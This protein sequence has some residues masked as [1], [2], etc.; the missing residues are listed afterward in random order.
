MKIMRTA[1]T[2]LVMLL[3]SV[4]LLHAQDLSK[5]RNFSLGMTLAD[6]SKQ[7]GAKPSDVKVIHQQ[8]ALIEELTWWP[9]L[10]GYPPRPEAIREVLFSFCDGKLYRIFV[11]YDDAATAGMTA[12][13]MARAISATYGTSTTPDARISF[14]T[15]GYATTEKVISRWEDSQYSVNLFRASFSST[16][17]LVMFTKQLN[18]EAE[19]A[20]TAAGKLEQQGAPQRE[21]DRKQ[22]EAD[23]LEASRVKNLKTFHP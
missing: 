22:K 18:A 20:I 21:V 1:I 12:E 3:L 5:Y 13:D 11:T 9:R 6:L 7:I 10:S 19:A 23:G 14:P 15:A 2:S 4:P 8:P 16:F 17:A